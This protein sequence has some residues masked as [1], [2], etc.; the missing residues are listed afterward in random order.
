M[1]LFGVFNLSGAT[2]T[3][4]L[5]NSKAN[6]LNK[7]LFSGII[8]TSQ[9]YP[10]ETP[11]S[12]FSGWYP[13]II[14]AITVSFSIVILY[15]VL[16]Y[17]L[18]NKS[19][20]SG[21]KA[22]L[23]KVLFT[24]V[25][26]VLV[27]LLLNWIGQATYS[28]S[29]ISKS[30]ILT[31]CQ[32]LNNPAGDNSLAFV[33]T[34]ATVNSPTYNICSGLIQNAGA[35][36]VTA[37]ID[38]GLGATYVI[39]SNLTNQAANNLNAIY[40]YRTYMAFLSSF[41]ATDTICYPQVTC[42]ETG[43]LTALTVDY[44]YKPFAGYDIISRATYI[45]STQST[46]VFY[47]FLLQLLFILLILFGWPYILAAGIILSASS[48]TRKAGGF[49]IAFVLAAIIIFPLI[50]L[51]EYS[52]LNSNTISPIGATSYPS[53]YLTGKD[54]NSNIVTYDKTGINFFVFPNAEYVIN[55]D[56]C[57][58]HGGLISQELLVIGAYGLPG[59]GLILGIINT[60]GSLTGSSPSVLPIPYF[61]CTPQNSINTI[62]SL[63][64]LY[65]MMSVLGII[66]P[67]INIFIGITA[68]IGISGLLGGT[69]S[70]LG[71][72]KLL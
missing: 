60:F 44:S 7:T 3:N 11:V 48:I 12:Q 50:F 54:L 70:I 1:L 56:G 42:L 22:E 67:L 62:F 10:L 57:W 25:I 5:L 13:V 4:I 33:N 68:T 71:L 65:G 69:T 6:I 17:I 64:N 18:N 40:V 38:Y 9:N 16:G 61:N 27:I 59:Y 31:I 41:T 63:I 47:S 37:N 72:N 46:V 29:L 58:P 8:L 26:L 21:G 28:T 24:A 52:T 49:L 55:N 20:V 35:L 39:L 15:Y 66:F 51:M 14:L 32:Q 36:N 43:T 34:A 45:L 53:V 23:E 30:S 2:T 19:M